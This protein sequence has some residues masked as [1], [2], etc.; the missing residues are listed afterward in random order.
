MHT[1][2]CVRRSEDNVQKLALSFRHVD[3]ED[4]TKIVR[5]G[6]KCLYLV[7][8]FWVPAFI[9]SMPHNGFNSNMNFRRDRLHLNHKVPVVNTHTTHNSGCHT[10][11]TPVHIESY[12]ISR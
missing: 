2:I 10:E 6:C 12:E 5:L 11:N 9:L 8:H 3:P 1:T 7:S 4:S